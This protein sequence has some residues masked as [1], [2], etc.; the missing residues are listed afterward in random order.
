[1]RI[2][3]FFQNL[4]VHRKEGV[5]LGPFLQLPGKRQVNFNVQGLF[6]LSYTVCKPKKARFPPKQSV[7]TY[8]VCYKDMLKPVYPFLF[9]VFVFLGPHFQHMEVPS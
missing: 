7:A 4:G 3:A 2:Q 8:P 9:C 5:L 1:M 6:Q